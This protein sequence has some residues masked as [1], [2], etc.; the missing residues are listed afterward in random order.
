M[1]RVSK[2]KW[3]G[4]V[5][6]HGN[7]LELIKEA[8][9][10]V[11]VER[12]YPR[13]FLFKCPDGCGDVITINLD[14][15]S[16]PAWKFYVRNGLRTLYPSVALTTGCQSHFILWRDD[17]LFCEGEGY[18]GN[19]AID[20]ALLATAYNGLQQTQLHFSELALQIGELPW[21]VLWACRE[22]VRTGHAKEIRIGYFVRRIK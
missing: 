22:L 19:I 21:E 3:L 5:E 14:P 2:I 17:I 18:R 11:L 16:G 8:G 1:S 7:G 20:K 12:G 9:D 6:R 4:I 15:A 13:S 10:C